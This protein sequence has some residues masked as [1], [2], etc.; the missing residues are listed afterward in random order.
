ME[1]GDRFEPPTS[2]NDQK[3]YRYVTKQFFERPRVKASRGNDILTNAAFKAF[4]F[5]AANARRYRVEPSTE[6]LFLKGTP[7]GHDRIITL[8]K[9]GLERSDAAP[10][11]LYIGTVLVGFFKNT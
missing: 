9:E 3:I 1:Y 2:S 5:K 11:Q 8:K 10:I 4:E 6:T 7:R